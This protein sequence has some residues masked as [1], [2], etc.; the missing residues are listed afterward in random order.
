MLFNSYMFVIHHYTVT[1]LQLQFHRYDKLSHSFQV[2]DINGRWVSK[3]N[4]QAHILLG[5]LESFTVDL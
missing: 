2:T 1:N 5:R 4:W 3:G